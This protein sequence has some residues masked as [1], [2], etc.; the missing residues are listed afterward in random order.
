MK[1]QLLKAG[2]Q[3]ISQC[4]KGTIILVGRV[5]DYLMA[6]IEY[7]GTEIS[8]KFKISN[9]WTWMKENMAPSKNEY[10]FGAR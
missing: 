5:G 7:I 8:D 6:F 9:A 1:G 10:F 3:A 2:I 4:F